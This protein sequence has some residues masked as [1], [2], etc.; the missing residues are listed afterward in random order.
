MAEQNAPG[1]KSWWKGVKRIP[2]WAV[3][4]HISCWKLDNFGAPSP[5]EVKAVAC[6]LVKS[7]PPGSTLTIWLLP[8]RQTN[9]N[10]QGFGWGLCSCTCCTIFNCPLRRPCWWQLLLR[11]GM[12]IGKS[13]TLKRCPRPWTFQFQT[14]HESRNS[15]SNHWRQISGTCETCN[16]QTHGRRQLAT[17]LPQTQYLCMLET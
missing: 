10:V 17:C 5:L 2:P 11:I 3:A 16:M 15:L 6:G 7:Q 8:N 13:H 14:T 9:A 1:Q 12:V 4:E